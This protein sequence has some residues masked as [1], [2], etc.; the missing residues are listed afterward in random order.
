MDGTLDLTRG[1]TWAEIQLVAA[2]KRLLLRSR[3]SIRRLHSL[4]DEA[5]NERL[6]F[7]LNERRR[8][9]WFRDLRRR[10]NLKRRE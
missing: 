6:L 1:R 10:L 8:R 9:D 3:E 2:E 5:R 4:P 7:L